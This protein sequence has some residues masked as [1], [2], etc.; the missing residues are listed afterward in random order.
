M[1]RGAALRV[2]GRGSGAV[3]ARRA[4]R[5]KPIF[6][7]RA[8]GATRRI[9]CGAGAPTPRRPGTDDDHPECAPTGSGPRRAQSVTAR[10]DTWKSSAT[11]RVRS[12]R[13]RIPSGSTPLPTSSSSSASRSLTRSTRASLP[14]A[15]RP[16]SVL[17]SVPEVR[18]RG[19]GAILATYVIW[20]KSSELSRRRRPRCRG[21]RR[22]PAGAGPRWRRARRSRPSRRGPRSDCRRSP[23]RARSSA[24]TLRRRPRRRG[25]RRTATRRRARSAP[26]PTPPG[27]PCG[28]RA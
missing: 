21:S 13:P 14:G 18:L 3:S 28:S 8:A 19:N 6:G 22:A 11:S 1:G 24:A 10:S 16:P 12:R 15:K 26:A 25:R 23:R 17:G 2:G 20:D 4:R 5:C 9:R 7:T 27:P